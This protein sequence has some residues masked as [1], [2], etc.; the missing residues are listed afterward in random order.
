VFLPAAR[1]LVRADGATFL[2]SLPSPRFTPNLLVAGA[3]IALQLPWLVLWL[4]GDRARGLGV[5]AA[6]TLVIALVAAWRPP[7]FARRTPAWR[8]GFAALRSIHTRALAR[9]AGDALVRGVGL[10][11]L[12]GAVAGLFV[13]NNHLV[14]AGA[15][16]MG[17]ATIAVVLIPAQVGPL[18]TLVESHR[19]T[20][21][22]A[23][24]LGI[25]P[26]VRTASLAAATIVVHAGATLIALVAYVVVD[27]PNPY[28]IVAALAIAIGS[29]L[30]ETRVL[31]TTDARPT[32]A[33]AEDFPLDNPPSLAATGS[34]AGSWRASTFIAQR[35][36]VGAVVVAAAAVAALGFLGFAGIVAYVALM[37]LVLLR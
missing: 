12:A 36:V 17:A 20:A 28:V 30:G 21:W 25:S 14:G 11:L 2:R 33:R 35:A 13:R 10:A 24:S 34:D 5:V 37:L 18:V 8:S 32:E 4:I 29:A 23:H 3:L 27:T 31:I 26:F 7:R 1:V 19:A 9:R 22:L 6:M 15:A 16:M